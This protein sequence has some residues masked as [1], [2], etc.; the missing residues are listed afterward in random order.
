MYGKSRLQKVPRI[1]RLYSRKLLSKSHVQQLIIIHYTLFFFVP[2]SAL[3]FC[4]H[5]VIHSFPPSV[6][7]YPFLLLL[8]PFSFRVSFSFLPPFSLVSLSFFPSCLALFISFCCSI[9]QSL[10]LLSF[11]PHFSPVFLPFLHPVKQS[12]SLHESSDGEVK[13]L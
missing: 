12:D 8:F 13:K 6:S 1:F 11:L 5:C 7:P 2:S 9:I 10:I 4:P 3:S